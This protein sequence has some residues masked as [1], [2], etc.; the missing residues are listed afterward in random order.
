MDTR[1]PNRQLSLDDIYYAQEH[2][3]AISLAAYKESVPEGYVMRQRRCGLKTPVWEFKG[4]ATRGKWRSTGFTTIE[5]A[6]MFV[7]DAIEKGVTLGEALKAFPPPPSKGH[8]DKA[9]LDYFGPD[10][11]LASLNA[12]AI[13]DFIE[14]RRRGIYERKGGARKPPKD[15]TIKRD[16]RRLH[17]VAAKLKMRGQYDGD[18]TFLVAQNYDLKCDDEFGKDVFIEEYF[19]LR[20]ALECEGYRLAPDYLTVFAADEC[21]AHVACR[22][23]IH[24]ERTPKCPHGYIEI[25]GSKTD[26]RDKP[27]PLNAQS[28]VLA[29]T[30][31]KRVEKCEDPDPLLFPELITPRGRRR[32]FGKVL[33]QSWPRYQE[34]GK[35]LTCMA[36]RR[37]CCTALR[38]YLD[39]YDCDLYLGH[40]VE[41]VRRHYD[42]LTIL[43]LAPKLEKVKFPFLPDPHG[44]S[45]GPG[46]R[47]LGHAGSAR[48][49]KGGA[50]AS[51]DCDPSA[52]AMKQ[53][54]PIGIAQELPNWTRPP[55]RIPSEDE[56]RKSAR[57]VRPA[58]E[59]NRPGCPHSRRSSGRSRGS[60][61]SRPSPP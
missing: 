24:L 28:R 10:F 2:G 43:D 46:G 44:T 21:A 33:R 23:D 59:C 37:T 7:W 19:D 22:S 6:R 52:T 56:K 49:A 45:G 60:A 35:K 55:E 38:Q 13:Q 25:H 47:T 40:K 39:G 29:E 42:Q 4:P 61:A 9:L 30:L 32:Q 50:G 14:A 12:A 36:L 20:G 16:I 34:L 5:E 8:S 51:D 48:E 15:D 27:K 57:P 31:L 11:P 26:D 53:S 58:R 17:R 54:Q 18:L 3:L 41:G 1:I